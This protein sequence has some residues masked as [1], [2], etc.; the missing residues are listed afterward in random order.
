MGEPEL[1]AA[2]EPIDRFVWIG[3]Y[4]LDLREGQ[5]M[6]RRLHPPP[7]PKLV[8]RLIDEGKLV[9]IGRKVILA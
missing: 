4:C 3:L 7:S 8:K 5:G 6:G 1:L 2:L 9:R